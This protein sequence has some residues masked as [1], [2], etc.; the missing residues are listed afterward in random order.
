MQ[1]YIF[2]FKQQIFFY[3]IRFFFYFCSVKMVLTNEFF[4]SFVIKI[5]DFST[6]FSI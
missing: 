4:G 1:S 2:S 6:I 5:Q 3:N